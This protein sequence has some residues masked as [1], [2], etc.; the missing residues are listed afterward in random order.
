[1]LASLLLVTLVLE[2]V[3]C[4]ESQEVATFQKLFMAKRIEQLAAVKNILK[5]DEQKRKILLDQITVKLFQVLSSSKVETGTKVT[6][7]SPIPESVSLVLENVCLASDLLLRLP[8]Q[9]HRKIKEVKDWVN[10]F[11]WAIDFSLE[12]NLLD[13]SSVKLLALASQELGL[14]EK[15]PQYINPYR[16]EKKP[17]KKFEDLPTPKKKERKKLKKGPKM[18]RGEL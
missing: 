8:D 2:K 18:S 10:I 7:T 4:Q 15:D 16:T 1:M 5:M 11:K 14:V 12:T 13:E 3:F 9:M 6:S 17:A